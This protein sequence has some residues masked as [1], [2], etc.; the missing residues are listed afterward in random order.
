MGVIT[1]TMYGT[2]NTVQNAICYEGVTEFK[3]KKYGWRPQLPDHR[4]YY[5]LFDKSKNKNVNCVD[6][7]DKCP[8]V[9][10]QGHLGSCT[11]NGIGFV[12]EFDMMKQHLKSFMPS[13][14]FL[15]YNERDMEGTTGYDAGANIRDG[16]KSLNK[17]GICVETEWPY[18]IS[19]FTD[20]PSEI[21]YTDAKKNVSVKYKKIVQSIDQF[22]AALIEGFPVV[23]GFTVYQSFESNEVEKTGVVNMPF[24]NEPILGGHCVA[25]VGFIQ[26]KKQFIVRNSWGSNWGAQGYCYFPYDYL[27]SPDLASDFWI[28]QQV[29]HDKV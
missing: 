26:D 1:S 6:L 7:R 18:D 23:F 25:I 24:P 4:D 16:I 15:Y 28:I 27:D 29:E 3:Y 20:K 17:Q 21:C 11:A 9:Y 13:R 10:D 22:K 8:P 5:H 12:F 2:V 14:L 19:K